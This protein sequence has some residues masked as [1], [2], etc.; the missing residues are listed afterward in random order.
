MTT[1]NFATPPTTTHLTGIYG[2]V[3]KNTKSVTKVVISC[4]GE[5]L[6]IETFVKCKNQECN[7]RKTPLKKVSDNTYQAVYAQGFAKKTLTI[8]HKGQQLIIHTKRT[9]KDSR[10]TSTVKDLLKLTKLLKKC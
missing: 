9:Y 3:D 1:I 2:N 7:W 6:F 10:P 4:K 8:V 5:Q